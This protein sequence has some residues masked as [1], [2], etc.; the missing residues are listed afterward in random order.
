M[1]CRTALG[2]A[3]QARSLTSKAWNEASEADRD[4]AA[5]CVASNWSVSDW[6]S[7]NG[8]EALKQSVFD[9]AILLGRMKR[10]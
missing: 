6:N 5:K 2:N 10:G 4:A 8:K 3:M 7:A 1:D 9:V